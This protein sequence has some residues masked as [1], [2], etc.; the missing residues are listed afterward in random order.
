M[1]V[2]DDDDFT[3]EEETEW[4]R[5]RS[6]AEEQ[7]ALDAAMRSASRSTAADDGDEQATALSIEPFRSLLP[8]VLQMVGAHRT[9]VAN[10]AAARM[11][12]LR[13]RIAQCEFMVAQCG[14]APRG[15]EEAGQ[16][17]GQNA[18]AEGSREG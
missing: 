4:G 14:A 7:D 1:L 3:L 10:S 9:G 15:A 13:K 5:T 17:H 8:L 6:S 12:A 11:S 18:T 2:L 16:N